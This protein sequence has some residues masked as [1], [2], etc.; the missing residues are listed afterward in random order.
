[1]LTTWFWYMV[2]TQK[3]HPLKN[4]YHNRNKCFSSRKIYQFSFKC[5]TQYHILCSQ[6]TPLTISTVSLRRPILTRLW[7]L[8]KLEPKDHQTMMEQKRSSFIFHQKGA[9]VFK[10]TKHIK[11]R[12]IKLSERLANAILGVHQHRFALLQGSLIR[13]SDVKFSV[14][15]FVCLLVSSV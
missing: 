10:E 6:M 2:V 1:M 8:S 9:T 4:F 14:I 15:R 5:G 13:Y 7:Y 11:L 12:S 3:R